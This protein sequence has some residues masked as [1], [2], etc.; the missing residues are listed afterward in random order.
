MLLAGVAARPCAWFNNMPLGVHS[1]DGC[2]H[3]ACRNTAL[4]LTLTLTLT[5]TLTLTQHCEG[6]GMDVARFRRWYVSLFVGNYF[7]E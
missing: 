3:T 2:Y 7:G 6:A 5:T 4:T 1:S